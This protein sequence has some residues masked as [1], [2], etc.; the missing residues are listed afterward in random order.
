MAKTDLSQLSDEQLA[1]KA[2]L[3]GIEGSFFRA[4][5]KRRQAQATVTATGPTP[6]P[7]P[8]QAAS[9]AEIAGL[10]A[11]TRQ[12]RRAGSIQPI[13]AIGNLGTVA[14]GMTGALRPRTLIGY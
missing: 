10:A 12:R 14:G 3:P 1:A 6:P 4:E 7:S 9:E 2:A 8:A 5:Q 13:G 11:R